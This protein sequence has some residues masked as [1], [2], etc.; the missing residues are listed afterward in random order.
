MVGRKKETAEQKL[1]KMIEAAGGSTGL[2]SPEEKKIKRRQNLLA[3]IKIFNSFL[4]G[5]IVLGVM[6]IV[7]QVHAGASL[8]AH[9]FALSVD[10]GVDDARS[11]GLPQVSELNQYMANINT[12][13]LFVPYEARKITV[14]VSPENREIVKRTQV[15]KM[16]G[17]AWHDSVESA[18]VM[19]EN[20]ER[21]ETYF[22]QV[23]Q[24]IG[25]IFVKTIY[26]DSVELGYKD[27]E[28]IITYDNTQK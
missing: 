1:L 20:T 21:G 23:G 12:R 10:E 4:I 6:L 16:V 7:Y 11:V 22:L 13:N 18:S 15:L 3:V 24:K 5:L 25:D 2:P 19:L 17:V 28:I 9:K 14:D 8:L 27:E 26:A